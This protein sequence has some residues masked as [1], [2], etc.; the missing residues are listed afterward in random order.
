MAIRN[1]AVQ[2][3]LLTR[4]HFSLPFFFF[5]PLLLLLL[6][7]V[8]DV[9]KK[10]TGWRKQSYQRQGLVLFLLPTFTGEKKKNTVAVRHLF[11]PPQNHRV[12]MRPAEK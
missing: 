3:N 12:L 10:D 6:F 11:F 4:F 1:I 9:V 8:Q 5:L 7:F 2:M